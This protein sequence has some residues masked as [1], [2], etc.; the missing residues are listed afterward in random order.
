LEAGDRGREII[1]KEEYRSP[2]FCL[3]KVH[4]QIF[5]FNEQNDC[6]KRIESTIDPN[7]FKVILGLTRGL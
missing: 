2:R 5:E 4:L 6:L 1:E 7:P 3:S